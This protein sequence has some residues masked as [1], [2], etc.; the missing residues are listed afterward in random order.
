MFY[1]KFDILQR[2]LRSPK[3]LTQK[4]NNNK[5][6]MGT[7]F[8]TFTEKKD[9]SKEK[10]PEDFTYDEKMALEVYEAMKSK[11]TNAAMDSEDDDVDM[12]P[13]LEKVR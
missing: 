5:H 3:R 9:A 11:R 8:I 12:E 7:L 13:M 4:K 10:N 2:R 1:L 6:F